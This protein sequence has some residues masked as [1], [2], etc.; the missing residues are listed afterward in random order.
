MQGSA[1]V[2]PSHFHFYVLRLFTLEHFRL[3]C[4][5]S[6]PDHHK[7]RDLVGGH[8]RTA[9]HW[10]CCIHLDAVFQTRTE[11]TIELLLHF[12][13]L[14][15]KHS[16]LPLSHFLPAECQAIGSLLCKVPQLSRNHSSSRCFPCGQL[17]WLQET[18]RSVEGVSLSWQNKHTAAIT[19]SKREP[20]D[21]SQDK[22]FYVQQWRALL[23]VS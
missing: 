18:R 20:Q 23:L 9:K 4:I 3:Q 1:I 16:A 5:S 13:L 10:F 22:G 19:E 15:Q 21:N 7:L 12:L 6:S 2:A 14:L 11:A 17:T 8:L